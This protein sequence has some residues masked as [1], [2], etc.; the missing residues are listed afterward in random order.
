MGVNVHGDVDSSVEGWHGLRLGTVNGSIDE[1]KVRLY[2]VDSGKRDA[3]VLRP[4]D[5]I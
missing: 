2:D 1:G 4:V 3:S 5:P